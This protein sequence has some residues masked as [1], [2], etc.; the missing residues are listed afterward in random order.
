MKQSGRWKNVEDIVDD[1]LCM[2]CGVCEPVCPVRCI[3][4]SESP[5]NG[6]L[7]PIVDQP[8]CVSGCDI[9]LR[10]CPG[11]TVDFDQL[12]MEFLGKIPERND[13][14]VV[15]RT[16]IGHASDERLRYESSSGGAATALLVY[17]LDNGYIDGAIVLRMNPQEPHVAEVTVART[18]EEILQSKGSKY[19]PAKSGIGLRA[20]MREP[21]RYAFVGV[22][23]HIHGVRKFQQVFKKYRSRIVIT[24]GLFCG[25]GITM[26]GTRFLLNRLNVDSSELVSLQLRGNGWPGKTTAVCRDGRVAELNKRAGAKDLQEAAVYNSWMHRYFTPPRCLTCTDL[27][28][29]LADISFGDPW[30]ARFVKTDKIGLSMMVVRSPIG[31]RLLDLAIR[32]QAIRIVD[33]ATVQEIADSQGKLSVKTHTRAFRIAASMLG[34]K[35]PDYKNLYN[36]GAATPV[37]LVGALWAYIRLWLG[38]HRLFWSILVFAERLSLECQQR[39]ALWRKLRRKI[40]TRGT[41]ILARA[42]TVAGWSRAESSGCGADGAMKGVSASEI[43]SQERAM[44]V[45]QDTEFEEL[46]LD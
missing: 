10:V 5:I 27:T 3:E 15:E 38:R 37:A 44:A 21:G 34:I 1:S 36:E 16:F 40:R 2:G 7:I 19:C 9:C 46:H 28:A 43:T 23:C 18:R 8:A 25:G 6:Q 26:H 20:V 31:A 30:L 39:M 14:G 45:S 11:E 32:D 35:T 13:V 4:I 17:L 33:E 12:N 41:N 29:Q 42:K 22:A 24:L